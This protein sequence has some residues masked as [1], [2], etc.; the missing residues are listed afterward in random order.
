M[1]PGHFKRESKLMVG[2]LVALIL[3][4]LV[5]GLFLPPVMAVNSEKTSLAQ[6]GKFDSNTKVC[7]IEVQPVGSG[8]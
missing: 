4:S 7:A 5:A 1:F 6:D 8:E 3:L 2:F